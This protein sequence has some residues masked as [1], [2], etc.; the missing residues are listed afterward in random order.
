[1]KLVASL[2]SPFARKVRI[3]LLEKRIDFQLEIDIPWE[4]HSRVPEFNPLGKVPVLVFDDGHSLFDSRVIV[5]YLDSISPVSRLIPQ[6]NRQAVAVRRWE[7]LADGI[8][9]AAAAIFIEKKRLPTQ[10][11]P[12]WIDRQRQK[13]ERGLL[14]MA[15]DLGDRNWCNG[16]AYSLADIAVGCCLAYL[17]LR[18][19]DISWRQ[20]HTN[21]ARL[22]DRLAQR[23]AFADTAPP[24]S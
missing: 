14:A 17:E 8:A 18:F 1:M 19:A 20:Q 11:S 24:N 9:D 16:E 5:E 10:Q 6:E 7:A 3:V 15:D 13:I 2:T 22:A 21:L 12:D 23:P 4:S